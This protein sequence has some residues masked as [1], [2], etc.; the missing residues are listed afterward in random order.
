MENFGDIRRELQNDGS[1][2]A[3]E[4]DG[5]TESV[6]TTYYIT[7]KQI[8]KLCPLSADLM[9]LFAF[10]DRQMVP[11]RFLVESGLDGATDK[12]SF[13][14][15]VGH[16]LEFSLISQV[17]GPK[18]NDAKSYD[19]HRLVHLSMETYVSQGPGAAA[20]WKERAVEI[21]SRLFPTFRYEDRSIC[22][23]Y[24]PHALAVIPYSDNA[25]LRENVADYLY[26][27]GEYRAAEGHL[28]RC[29]EIG[30]RAGSDTLTVAERLGG[31]YFA[32]GDYNKAIEW[33]GRA[34]A[35]F[36]KS[37]GNDHPSTLAT[38]NN[39]AVVYGNQGDYSKA[40]EWYGR[41]L[42]GKEKSLGKDHPDTLTTV[43]NMAS[44]YVHQGDY[45]KALEWYGRALAG[46][47]KSLG[48]DHPSTLAT[49]NNMAV[50]Y[51]NQGDYSK[52]LEW[53]GR[54]LAGLEKS[55]GKDHPDT[56]ATVNNMASVYTTK[57]TT[58]KHSNGTA[59]RWL[60]WKSRLGKTTPTH[61]LPSTTWHRCMTP[62]RLQQST[63]MVRPS[64]GWMEKSLGKDHPDTLTTVNNMALV[65]TTKATTAKH[66]NGTAERWLGGKSRLGKTTPTHSLPSTTWHRCIATKAT[67]A[68]HSN[69]TAERWLVWKS[70]LGKTTPTHSLLS[71]TWH[72]CMTTKATTAKHS[73][74]TAERWLEGKVAWERPPPHSLL[75]TTWHGC[76]AT[77]A[78][79]AKHS[80]GT[81][82]RWLVRKSRLGKTTPTH[83]LLSTTWHAVY[84][85]QGDYSKALEWY[86]RALAGRE[87]S[88]GNDHPDTLTTVNNMA[89]GV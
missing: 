50:V 27:K 1:G 59:E 24:L 53:Y 89:S 88:L 16:L 62:R 7:F 52:A 54:A 26:F 86:G 9:R 8:Q 19:V 47:E 21:V 64:A 25:E 6:L 87:K 57:A 85:N 28:M 11:E 4:E 39:M 83:S 33:H 66:S 23:A 55:L 30:E 5:M 51:S 32:Q 58:A 15:A 74:G 70:R 35:G 38:V 37:L 61:S 14:K 73:N 2:G 69:G 31:V 43:N 77:K 44:V 68:K 36:E 13:R 45:S 17:S 80:N 79:T 48:K 67:T 56:L 72:R 63:R 41:A 81:A 40:L 65:Y 29:I 18:S 20:V 82:E 12:I 49:V 10:L 22:S 34:L 84:D 3:E 42:A 75:S 71:T 60:V 76:I 78:T 46:K